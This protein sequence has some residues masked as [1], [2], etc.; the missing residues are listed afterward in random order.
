MLIGR[1]DE[2]R[3]LKEAFSSEQSEFVAVYGRRRVGKTFLV[4]EVF[5]YKFTF[6]HA[7]ISKKPLKIQL[8][9]FRAS[10]IKQG[11]ADCPVFRI[12]MRRLMPWKCF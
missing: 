4:R 10:L 8:T 3:R 7:G 6:Q 11:Y 9:R 1:K 12:G 2:I 5:D